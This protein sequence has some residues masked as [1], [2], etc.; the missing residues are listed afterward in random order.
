MGSYADHLLN[1]K[2]LK[3][4]DKPAIPKSFSC[5]QCQREHEFGYYVAAHSNE[6]LL[7]TCEYGAQHEMR[8][9]RVRFVKKQ[10]ARN[11]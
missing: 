7:H 11:L 10:K 5:T 6:S 2:A 3:T 1:Q 4:M 9:Y 8:H